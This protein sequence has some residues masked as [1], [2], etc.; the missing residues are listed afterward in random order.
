MSLRRQQTTPQDFK[1]RSEYIKK[2]FCHENKALLAAKERA[3]NIYPEMMISPQEGKILQCLIRSIQA[4]KVI[5]IGAFTGYSALWII[6]ALPAN[7]QFW[8]LELKEEHAHLSK[9]SLSERKPSC[10]YQVIQGPA[11]KSLKILEEHTPFD[12]IFI[13]ANKDGYI[14][15]LDWSEKHLRKGGLIIADNAYLFGHVYKKDKP[16]DVSLEAWTSMCEFNEKLSNPKKYTSTIL[17]T[18]EGMAI[19]TKEF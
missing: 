4:Q 2:L 13:D 19:A 12:A 6:Q 18:E 14:Q 5:E 11:S 17:P 8:T 9:L 16:A 1:E 7:G 3:E 10:Q 15:Y